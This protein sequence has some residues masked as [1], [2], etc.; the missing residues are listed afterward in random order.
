MENCTACGL[1]NNRNSGEK[2]VP[3]EGNSKAKIML[4]GEAPGE[5]EAK[6]GRPFVGDA[7]NTLDSLLKLA[8]IDRKDIYITN[9]NKC[10]PWEKV[11]GRDGFDRVLNRAPTKEEQKS[12]SRYLKQEIEMVNPKVIVPLG[13]VPL[14]TLTGKAYKIGQEHGKPKMYGKS[15]IY[16]VPTYHPSYVLRN[17]GVYRTFGD[18]ELTPLAKDVVDDLKLIKNICLGNIVNPT[19][20]YLLVDTLEKLEKVKN[21]IKERKVCS[22]DIE[23]S[24][25]DIKMKIFGIGFGVDVGKACYIPFLVRPVMEGPMEDFWGINK[26]QVIAIIKEILESKEIY[27]SAHNAKFD[28]RC[29]KAN[30]GIEVNNLA[31]DTLAGAY[32]I[33][34]NSEHGLKALKNMFIDLLGYEDEWNETTKKGKEA[35]NASLELICQYNCS[36]CD[37]TY[38]LTKQ[39]KEYFKDKPNLLWYMSE[40]YIPLMH[41][42]CDMEF[43]GVMYDSERAKPLLAEFKAQQKDIQQKAWKLVE[44]SHPEVKSFDLDSPDDLVK[45]LYGLL[46]LTP[47]GKTEKGKPSTDAKALEILAEKH[48]LPKLIVDYRHAGKMASTYIERMLEELDERDRIHLALHPTGTVTGRLSSEGLQNIPRDSII[49][50]LFITSEGF[51][52][53]QGD[54]SQAEVRC[55]AHYANEEDMIKEFNRGDIDVHCVVASLILGIPYEEF[56]AKYKSGDPEAITAR[57]DAKQSTFGIS[58]GMMVDSLAKRLNKTIPEAQVVMNMFFARFRKAKIWIEGVHR[59]VVEHGYVYNIFGR[60]R[61]I[62]WALSTDERIVEKAKRQAVNSIIQATAADITTLA[63][64]RIHKVLKENQWPAKLVL[65]VHD[66]IVVETKDEYIEQV[67]KLLIDKMTEKPTPDFKVNMQA[68]VDIYQKWGVK[69]KKAA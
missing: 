63:L 54:L 61:K 36:D 12:C 68:D 55:L 21:I 31:W 47:P 30:F 51:K 1:G 29:L 28:M 44:L 43:D 52:L 27:K 35:A 53:V 16:V 50:G 2:A 10:R 66:S 19:K 22:F 65:T 56:L 64:V 23:G 59:F 18:C 20:N 39:Q 42:I 49:K 57:S 4:V 34:E 48:E 62:P 32:L 67:S 7:G 8:E 3:G 24:G 26:E 13:N 45:V 58:Y 11:K 46:K 25:L 17:G 69:L 6:I 41:T 60:V 37:A 15:N 5:T 33:D 38:R 9:T 40:L 14:S